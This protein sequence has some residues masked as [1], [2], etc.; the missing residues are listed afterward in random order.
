MR[1]SLALALV[2]CALASG[3]LA[4]DY[5][6]DRAELERLV[7]LPA[8]ERGDSVRVTQQTGFSS[9]IRD[10]DRRSMPGV[11]WWVDDRPAEHRPLP[12]DSGPH[13]AEPAEAALAAIAVAAV[14]ASTAA[15]TVGVTEGA[16]FDGW[17]AA[18]AKQPL[19]LIEASGGRRWSRLDELTPEALSGVERAVMPE[20]DSELD[21]LRRAPLARRGFVY[22]LELGVSPLA[23]SLGDSM[24][25]VAGRAALGFMPEQRFGVL[26]GAAFAAASTPLTPD[27]AAVSNPAPGELSVEYRAFLQAEYWPLRLGR[28]LHLGAFGEVGTGWALRD[29][30][31]VNRAATGLTAGAGVA[32][33]LDVSTRL[34]ATLRWGALWL[35]SVDPGG[36][37]SAGDGH[38]LASALTLGVSIY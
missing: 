28:R 11:V 38:R 2:V 10:Q 21:R 9:D 30:A 31:R 19:L 26:F 29:E 34:A 27:G 4:H 8:Q 36:A 23:S 22:Q 18:P 37:L 16:R 12:R 15:V 33:Q 25:G 13:E 7:A 35:P 32:L 6:L 3:C 20:L 17:L 1:R 5:A 14:V 24:L